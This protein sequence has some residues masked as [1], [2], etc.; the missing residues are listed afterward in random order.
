MAPH[1]PATRGDRHARQ[2]L[3]GDESVGRVPSIRPHAV[4]GLIAVEIVR[5]RLCGRRHQQMPGGD[6]NGH[7]QSERN[8]G[9]TSFTRHCSNPLVEPV[10]YFQVSGTDPH[11]CIID[12][13]VG[14]SPVRLLFPIYRTI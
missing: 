7:L 14:M 10:F 8:C 12:D 1:F 11:W 4:A 5:E 3:R 13:T 9:R 2:R 6:G